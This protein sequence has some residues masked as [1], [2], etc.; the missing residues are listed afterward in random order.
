MVDPVPAKLGLCFNMAAKIRNAFGYNCSY[1]AFTGSACALLKGASTIHSV[2]DIPIME[3]S[4]FGHNFIVDRTTSAQQE[5]L[6]FKKDEWKNK[7]AVSWDEFSMITSVLAGKGSMAVSEF[8]DNKDQ[9]PFGGL[10]YYFCGD[11]LQLAPVHG[12]CLYKDVLIDCGILDKPHGPSKDPFYD[13]I[14]HPRKQGIEAFKKCKL[15]QLFQQKRA[16]GD[17][18]HTAFLDALRNLDNEYPVTQSLINY[19]LE[20]V[21]TS[22]DLELTEWITAPVTVT[23][24]AER[25]SLTAVMASDFAVRMGVPVVIW[26]HDTTSDKTKVKNGRVTNQQGLF[27]HVTTTASLR[28]QLYDMSTGTMGIFIQGAPAY[29]DQ[30]CNNA[31]ICPMVFWWRCILYTLMITAV[32][33]NWLTK[34]G[35]FSW[36]STTLCLVLLSILVVSDL[37]TS[38]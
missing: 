21:L 37:S 30:N 34:Y 33:L 16:E 24:N 17:S 15:S 23:S 18:R 6:I 29:I 36:R 38:M 25:Y 28:K 13:N 8:R 4:D 5:K 10:D 12:L 32:I 3:S 1:M 9:S 22:K 35:R 14:S 11:F 31:K 20:H 27:D 2:L 7:H 19:L 26:E